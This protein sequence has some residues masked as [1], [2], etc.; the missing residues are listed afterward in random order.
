MDEDVRVW[1]DKFFLGLSAT[2]WTAAIFSAQL[3][4]SISSTFIIFAALSTA[5]GVYYHLLEG[6]DEFETDHEEERI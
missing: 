3:N 1:L 6:D 4:R 5:T 2:F